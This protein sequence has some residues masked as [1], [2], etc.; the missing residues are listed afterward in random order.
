MLNY[1]A[2]GW[3]AVRRPLQHCCAFAPVFI[4]HAWRSALLWGDWY[5]MLCGVEPCCMCIHAGWC[6]TG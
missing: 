5:R 6:D 1:G 4:L 2:A 3:V